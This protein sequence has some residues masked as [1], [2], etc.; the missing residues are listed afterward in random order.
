MKLQLTASDKSKGSRSPRFWRNMAITGLL[1]LLVGALIV[2]TYIATTAARLAKNTLTPPRD[3]VDRTPLDAGIEGYEDVTFAASDGVTLHGWYVLPENGAVIILAHGYAGNRLMLLPEARV[4]VGQGYGALLFDFRGHG[5]SEGD[6][7]TIGDHERRDLDAAIDF[8]A[9]QPGVEKIGAIGFSM[10]AATLA[11]VAA[12]DERLDAVVIEA[13]FPTLVEEIRYRSRAFGPLSQIPTL[14]AVRQSGVDVD[15]VRPIDNL[16]AISP[17]P[18]LLI[19]GELDTD[20]PPG[21]AQAMF[22]EACDPV[23]LW[24]V[25][26]ATHQ[27]YATIVPGEY[28]ARLLSFFDW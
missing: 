8:V 17:R 13:A 12:R 20:V 21:T 11:Q 26:G 25:Q 1:V 14:R 15:H 7:V 16:C 19:Y 9:A 24:V 2:A 5:E 28:A 4:L 10:G 6:L 3:P 23:A 27:N 22:D 18:V